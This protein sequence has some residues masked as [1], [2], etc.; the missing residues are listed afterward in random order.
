MASSIKLSP[1]WHSLSNSSKNGT[2][3]YLIEEEEGLNDHNVV[4]KCAEI[5]NTISEGATSFLFTEYLCIGIFMVAF[6]IL[7]FVLLGFVEGFSTK[8]QPCLYNKGEMCKPALANAIFNT[9][10][11][12]LGGFT[13]LLYSFLGMLS[14]IAIRL[15]IDAYGLINDN[16][17]GI[18]EMAGIDVLCNDKTRTLTLD[19]LTVGK[20]LIK[21]FIKVVE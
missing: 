4:Y 21:V 2:T 17:R 6:A 3:E 19:K 1:E 11:F 13:S 20:N 5:Q 16:A 8:S 12:L 14:T 18:V 10:S 7:I 9:I 15:A